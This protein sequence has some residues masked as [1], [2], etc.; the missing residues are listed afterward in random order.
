MKTAADHEIKH[1]AA[2]PRAQ[3]IAID[4]LTEMAR[5][6]FTSLA[7]LGICAVKTGT[8]TYDTRIAACLL[9]V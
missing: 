9:N 3:I 1:R 4:I 2:V 8:S 7:I 6:C 5:C